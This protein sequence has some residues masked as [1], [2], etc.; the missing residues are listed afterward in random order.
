MDCFNYLIRVEKIKKILSTFQISPWTHVS[1]FQYA[2]SLI[3]SIFNNFDIT[4]IRKLTWKKIGKIPWFQTVPH[5][6]PLNSTRM[7]LKIQQGQPIQRFPEVRRFHQN[8]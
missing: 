2:V 4:E 3:Y 1:T 7:Q 8:L 5:H 6:L